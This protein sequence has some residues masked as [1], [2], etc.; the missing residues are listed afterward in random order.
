MIWVNW[1]SLR[2]LFN[3]FLKTITFVRSRH[4]AIRISNMFIVKYVI[5]KFFLISFWDIDFLFEDY[6]D[7]SVFCY[8]LSLRL[9]SIFCLFFVIDLFLNFCFLLDFLLLRLKSFVFLFSIF[10]FF[11][12]G[13]WCAKV[14]K[15]VMIEITLTRIKF[16]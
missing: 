11:D 12:L 10:S 7:T 15:K 5:D 13:M 4:F 1:S 2:I 14:F 6:C 3:I 9:L 16:E 8:I